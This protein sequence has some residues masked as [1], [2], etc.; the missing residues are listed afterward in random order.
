MSYP[1]D[2]RVGGVPIIGTSRQTTRILMPD[3]IIVYGRPAPSPKRDVT[4]D[5]STQSFANVYT[6]DLAREALVAEPRI[7]FP[8]GSVILREKRPTADGEPELLS[9]M[10]KRQRGFNRKANDWEFLLLNGT[11]T[12]VLERQK[13]GS[14]L[15]CHESQVQRDYVYSPTNLPH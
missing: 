14:C 1:P 15:D 12:K 2:W 10:I 7:Q 8:R 5:N 13:K 9:V 11:G 4:H 3:S 6:N